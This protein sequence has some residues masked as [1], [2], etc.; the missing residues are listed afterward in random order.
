MIAAYNMCGIKKSMND[1][2]VSKSTM[3][4]LGV[5]TMSLGNVNK[6]DDTYEVT[7]DQDN[8]GNYKKIVHKDGVI[9][10]ALIQGDLSYTGV[11]MQLIKRKIDVSKVKKPLFK[12]DYSDFFRVT[13]N[14][15]FKYD[16]QEE[17]S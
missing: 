7:I 11:L 5:P 14:F 3:N 4:F 9:V 8:K 6:Y 10:G 16:K 2:F 15:E 17:P 12:I 13:D 1:F